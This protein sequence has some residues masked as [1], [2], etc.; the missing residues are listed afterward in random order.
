MWLTSPAGH[1]AC[2]KLIKGQL[3]IP[4]STGADK[5]LAGHYLDCRVV[6]QTL[7]G[8]FE[9]FRSH[10]SGVFLFTIGTNHTLRG[11]WWTDG[12]VPV[13][14]RRDLTRLSET[15]PGMVRTVWVRMPKAKAPAW[16]A[17]YFLEWPSL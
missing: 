9:R 17:Q 12:D 6:E 11:G 15:L 2:A 14:V 5:H 10:K 4:Y 1:I 16:A 3:L 7:L 8:R 13:T